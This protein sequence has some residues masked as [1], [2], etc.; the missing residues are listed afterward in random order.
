MA[1]E[2]PSVKELKCPECG[3]AEL[4]ILGTKG[5]GAAAISVGVLAGA[6]GSMAMDKASKGDFD[7]KPVKYQCL[8]CKK[9]FEALPLV[10]A[11]SDV[12]SE[13]C[14]VNFTR[15][16]SMVGMAVSQQ[17]FLNGVKVGNVKNGAT[18]TFRTYTKDNTVFVTDQ[19][20]LAF[21]GSYT[22]TAE[23]GG[24]EDIKFKRKFL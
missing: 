24:T 23:A 17:V 5:A 13:P 18:L 4:R 11:E 14:T 22:F 16:G 19:Y 20:G 12:L 15:L 21:P 7:I 9:K 3:A 8:K 2:Y 6:I 10:A 1:N